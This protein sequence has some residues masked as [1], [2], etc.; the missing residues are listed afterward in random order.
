MS[1]AK[2]SIDTIDEEWNSGDSE[3]S[4]LLANKAKKET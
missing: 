2:S 3:P 1:V 4:V